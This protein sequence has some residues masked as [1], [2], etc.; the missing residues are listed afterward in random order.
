MGLAIQSEPLPL[1]MDDDGAVR[2]G[3]TRVTLD[4]VVGAHLEGATPQDIARQYPAVHLADI[5]VV[6]GYYLRN[7]SAID[8]YLSERQQS[9]AQIQQEMEKLFDPTGVRERLEKRRLDQ[10]GG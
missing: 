1:H 8:S 9:A 2:V 10:R 6:I 7:T 5:Y 3:N 4:I